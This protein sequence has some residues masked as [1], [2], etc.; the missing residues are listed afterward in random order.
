M[1]V[2]S[3]SELV[4]GFWFVVGFF[5]HFSSLDFAVSNKVQYGKSQPKLL[6]EQTFLIVKLVKKNSRKQNLK[7]YL[8]VVL[9]ALSHIILKESSSAAFCTSS[10]APGWPG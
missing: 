9:L 4:F 8:A 2:N 3:E 7:I 6:K 5:F 10:L 1:K